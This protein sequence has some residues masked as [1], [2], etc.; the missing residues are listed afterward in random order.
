MNETNIG[1]FNEGATS[2]FLPRISDD[3]SVGLY[4]ALTNKSLKGKELVTWGIAN[5]YMP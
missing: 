5:Y 4:L 3:S 1:Y 2:F